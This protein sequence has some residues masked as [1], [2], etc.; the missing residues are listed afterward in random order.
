MLFAVE[1]VPG[2]VV[3]V[4]P[5][6]VPES[7]KVRDLELGVAVGLTE[8]IYRCSLPSLMRWLVPQIMAFPTPMS[9]MEIWCA[10]TQN[11]CGSLSVVVPRKRNIIGNVQ[12]TTNTIVYN[13]N[14]KA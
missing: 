11:G 14:L 2:A 8:L 10:Q 5:V 13:D 4:V 3:S 9:D 6:P 7:S 12:V 1:S